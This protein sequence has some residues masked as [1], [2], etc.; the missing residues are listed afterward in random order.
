MNEKTKNNEFLLLDQSCQQWMKKPSSINTKLG[1][2]IGVQQ[3]KLYKDHHCY[4]YLITLQVQKDT[5]KREEAWHQVIN[6]IEVIKLD[7][8]IMYSLLK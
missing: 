4:S 8:P 6:W 3:N 5:L 7:L 1:Q 2:F